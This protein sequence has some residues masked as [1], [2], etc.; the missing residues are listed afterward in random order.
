MF[1]LRIDSECVRRSLRVKGVPFATAENR[2]HTRPCVRRK[3]CAGNWI[4]QRKC[5]KDSADG[6]IMIDSSVN[7]NRNRLVL[8]DIETR[9]AGVQS[10]SF[11]TE[12]SIATEEIFYVRAAAPCVVATDV[13]IIGA[14]D[15]ASF[16][17]TLHDVHQ[18]RIRSEFGVGECI[19]AP[20][21]HVPFA[22]AIPFGTWRRRDLLHFFSRMAIGEAIAGVV[23]EPRRDRGFCFGA[24][25]TEKPGEGNKHISNR[26]TRG[27]TEQGRDVYASL[28]GRFPRDGWADGET[29]QRIAPCI[30]DGQIPIFHFYSDFQTLVGQEN[31]SHD[32]LGKTP[33]AAALAEILGEEQ[34]KFVG[35]GNFGWSA[36]F[37]LF[38]SRWWRWTFFVPNSADTEFVFG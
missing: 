34:T 18:R 22:I 5:A 8:E 19:C 15:W 38:S 35:I 6:M 36:L 23:T 2:T 16:T 31:G 1:G 13:A 4:P 33:F 27:A 28:R 12:T 20:E 3:T 11:N 21:I 17:R 14:K 30:F 26:S 7:K 32:A 10:K 29:V 24:F 9:L 37:L 25:A